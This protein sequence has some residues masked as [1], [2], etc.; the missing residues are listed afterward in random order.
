MRSKVVDYKS[1]TK[2]VEVYNFNQII[3]LIN[4]LSENENK[5][6]IDGHYKR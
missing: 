6:S 2:H 1:W 5:E 3:L 4:N